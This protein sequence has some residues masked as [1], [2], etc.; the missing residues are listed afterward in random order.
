MLITR[1]ALHG[2]MDGWI[3][4]SSRHGWC[5]AGGASHSSDAKAVGGFALTLSMLGINVFSCRHIVNTL[6]TGERYDQPHT[7]TLKG[8]KFAS[9]SFSPSLRGVHEAEDREASAALR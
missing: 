2:W 8:W 5:P 3:V 9:R 4:P 7:H 6:R 1:A